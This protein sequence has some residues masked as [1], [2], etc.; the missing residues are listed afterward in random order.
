ML[1]ETRRAITKH[2]FKSLKAPLLQ[3]LSVSHSFLRIL[4]IPGIGTAASVIGGGAAVSRA[5]CMAPFCR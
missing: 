4:Y 5:M 2:G 1:G 3:L